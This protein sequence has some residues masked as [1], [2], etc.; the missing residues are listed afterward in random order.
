MEGCACLP[1]A[2]NAGAH[3][4]LNA[5]PIVVRMAQHTETLRVVSTDQ[6]DLAVTTLF[7]CEGTLGKKTTA[8]ME[9]SGA[10]VLDLTLITG[11]DRA[12]T[13]VVLWKA[14]NTEGSR[15]S[16]ARQDGSMGYYSRHV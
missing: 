9:A 13:K 3:R 1:R 15:G 6:P 11:F 14:P 10:F 16:Y 5:A 8:H 12:E 4:N 2:R 7:E